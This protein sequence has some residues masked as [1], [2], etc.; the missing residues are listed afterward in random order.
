MN[1]LIQL[2]PPQFDL[3]TPLMSALQQ[4]R[5][6]RRWQIEP[7]DYPTIANLLWAA[8]GESRPATKRCKNRRTMPSARNAQTVSVYLAIESGVFHYLEAE[9]A[10][11][12]ICSADLRRELTRQKMLKCMPAGLIYVADYS[13]MQGYINTD[14][15]RRL[16]VA[17]TEAGCIS[18]NV[19]LYCA[20]ADL[21]SV[22]IGLV[23]RELL[24]NKLGFEEHQKVIYTQAVGHG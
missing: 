2:P 1:N 14:E 19:A 9:H 20:A 21:H 7:L 23:D 22:L 11:R 8:C 4:R 13:R 18:Q 5:S 10:L 16:L 12:E 6:K 15:H 3:N 24:A 17:G